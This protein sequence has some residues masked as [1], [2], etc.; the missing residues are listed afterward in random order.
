MQL[1][2]ASRTRQSWEESVKIAQARLRQGLIPKLDLDQFE[3]ERANAA[4]RTAELERQMVQKENELSVLLGRNPAAIPRGRSLLD[5]ALPAEVPPGLPAELL[6]RRPDVLQSELQLAAATASIGVDTA[7]RFPKITLT[8][9]LGVAS[10]QLSRIVN[11]GQF[12]EVGPSLTGP[13]FNARILGFQQQAAEAQAR[14]AVAQYEQT[15]LVAFREVEDSIVA[16]STTRVA[17]LAQE[18]QV[19][20]KSTR[21]NSSH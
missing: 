17:A 16:V 15:I 3:A 13:L 19:D 5:Q 6:Q 14:Q 9:L 11:P 10:P 20:R 1:D 18:E 21:L 8:G 7:E 4:A 12:G 2:I